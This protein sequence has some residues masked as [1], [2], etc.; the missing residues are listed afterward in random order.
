MWACERGSRLM[1]ASI[2]TIGAFRHGGRLREAMAAF[3]D[4][5]RPWLDLSTGINPEPWSGQRAPA[6]ALR[7]LPDPHALADLETVAA[8][9][10]GVADAGRVVATSGAEAAL[11]LLPGLIGGLMVVLGEGGD[12]RSAQPVRLRMGEFQRRDFLE[13]V[14][15]QPRMVEQRGQDQRLAARHRAALAAHDRAGGELRARDH[16]RRAAGKPRLLRAA[17]KAAPPLR[18]AIAPAA[19]AAAAPIAIATP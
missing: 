6:D 18:P 16:I 12:D 7:R 15:E 5:P 19:A 17:R 9:A 3:P 11:R 2:S 1:S 13:M 14:L 10:F 8:R 4:A